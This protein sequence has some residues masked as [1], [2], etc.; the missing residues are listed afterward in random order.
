MKLEMNWGVG[1][2]LGYGVFL[3]IVLGTVFFSTTQDVNLVTED[4]YEKEIAYQQ[5][6]DK[7]NRTKNLPEQIVIKVEPGMIRFTFP[8]MFK[9]SEIAGSLHMYRPSSKKQDVQVPIALDENFEQVFPTG[10]IAK[11]LWEINVDWQVNGVEYFNKK[12]V[13][14]N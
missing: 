1:I 10:N 11:G 13:L 12:R 3:V 8:E 2:F 7:M 9:E 4:Y 5:Q 6:I 14:I